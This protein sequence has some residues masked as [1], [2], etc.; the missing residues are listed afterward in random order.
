VGVGPE[1]GGADPGRA[2]YGFGT[3][4]P[5]PDANLVL[6]RFAGAGL[7]GDEMKLDDARAVKVLDELADEMSQASSRIV[8]REE[9]ALGV[10]RVANANMERALRLVSIES[11]QDTGLF[12]LV[13]LGSAG[14]V[15]GC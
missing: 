12:T 7:L 4:P 2:C 11:G 10:I 6:G 5:L 8:T 15:M 13:R 1:W 14:V 3:R 9:A